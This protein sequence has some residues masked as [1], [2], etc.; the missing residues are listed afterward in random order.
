M[1]RFGGILTTSSPSF[2]IPPNWRD[3]EGELSTEM[4]DQMNYQIYP[5]HINKI[6]NFE[7]TNYSPPP[8]LIYPNKLD[9]NHSLLLFSPLLPSALLALKTSKHSIN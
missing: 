6:T 7:K 3:L 4:L 8:Y 1:E 9:D 2:L 5:Y